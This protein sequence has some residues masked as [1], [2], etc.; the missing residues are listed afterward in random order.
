MLKMKKELCRMFSENWSHNYKN[1]EDVNEYIVVYTTFQTTRYN[2]V[3]LIGNTEN[4]DYKPENLKGRLRN[5][6]LTDN[7]EAKVR[8]E[9]K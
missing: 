9:S 2:I 4:G 3:Q 5:F 7:K 8:I 1:I 6:K